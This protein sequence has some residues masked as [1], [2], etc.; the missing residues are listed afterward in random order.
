M[1]YTR[2]SKTAWVAYL[3]ETPNE[4]GLRRSGGVISLVIGS[5]CIGIGKMRDKHIPFYLHS[6]KIRQLHTPWMFVSIR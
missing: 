3:C 4:I 6:G 1:R 2:I 5:L